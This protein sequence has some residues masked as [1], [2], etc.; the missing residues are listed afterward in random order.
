MESAWPH[1]PLGEHQHQLPPPQPE[2]PRKR[3]G[4][5]GVAVAAA[6]AAAKL[7]ALLLFLPKLKL[8]TTSGTMLLSVAAY[9]LFFG[10]PFAV[11]FVILILVHE[12]GH[13]IQLRREG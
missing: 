2:Q 3:R 11:G 5:G 12:M 7:K 13:V 9:T 6:A 1:Q 10:L 4:L 8:L